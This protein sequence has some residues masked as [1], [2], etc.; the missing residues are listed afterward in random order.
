MADDELNSL[1]FDFAGDQVPDDRTA[2]TKLRDERDS[3]E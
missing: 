3:F 2:T 1:N